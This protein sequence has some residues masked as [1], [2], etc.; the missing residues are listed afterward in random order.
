MDIICRNEI[1]IIYI[2]I[3]NSVD[4]VD[5]PSFVASSVGLRRLLVSCV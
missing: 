2:T 1:I 3:G 5:I 4:P